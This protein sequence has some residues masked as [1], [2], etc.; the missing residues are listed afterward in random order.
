MRRTPHR[1]LEAV[2]LVFLEDRAAASLPDGFAAAVARAVSEEGLG[3]FAA[4]AHQAFGAGGW[5]DTALA[6][7][8]PVEALQKEEK[9]DP[10]VALAIVIDTSG[11]MGGNRVQLAKETARLAMRRLLPHDKVGIVEFYGAKRWAAPIQPASNNIELER[12]LNRLAAGGGTVI[13]P[14]IEEAFYG[15]LNVDAR[16]K[17]VL[18]LTDGGVESGAFEPLLRRMAS[19]GITTSTVLIGGDA[20]SEFLVTLAN[21]GKGRFYSVPNRFNLPEV[22]FKQPTSAKLSGVRPGEAPVRARGGPGWWGDMDPEAVPA[23]AS[24]VETELRPGAERVLETI[25]GE[26]PVLSSWRYGLGRVTAMPTEPLGP[27]TRPFGDWPD[28][29]RFLARTLERTARDLVPFTFEVERTTELVRITALRRTHAPLR[30]QARLV[31]AAGEVVEPLR[32]E[33]RAPGC[34]EAELLA[35]PGENLRFEGGV[36]WDRGS[37]SARDALRVVRGAR[38]Q[39][40]SPRGARPGGARRRDGWRVRGLRRSQNGRRADAR[41]AR[42]GRHRKRAGIARVA[43]VAPRT[44]VGGLSL[45]RL[46]PPPHAARD[47]GHAMNRERSSSALQ[48][49]LRAYVTFGVARRGRARAA[50]RRSVRPG[51]TPGRRRT[52]CF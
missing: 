14:A 28:Y 51:R 20:H 35:D 3:L 12:A 25:E 9:R 37:R 18:V 42:D 17:H 47:H 4:G 23:V 22:L 30:P 16:Y 27:G 33:Q 43:P 49:T 52:R 19:R 8:L 5:Q 2:D 34:F 26:R 46:R 44:R 32:F 39:P 41:L 48:R 15:L 7:V 31:S 13:L 21:W 29:G 36:R 6:D 11:S 1:E 38:R 45:R 24:L 10:S 50:C 40:R